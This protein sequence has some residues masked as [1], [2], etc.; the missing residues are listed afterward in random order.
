ML[1]TSLSSS[2]ENFMETLLYGKE[3]L[4]MKDVLATLNSRESK[5]RTKGTKEE[6]GDGLYVRKKRDYL[7]KK[8]SGFVK[9]GKRDQDF[10]SSN[11]E[12]N[13]YFGEAMV[14]VENDE[15]TE[16]VMDSGG[17]YHMTYK[18]DFLYEFKVVDGGS[19]RLV[20]Q[21]RL[22]DKQLEEKTNM[23]CLVKE[24]EKVLLG[25]KVGANI[26]VT[27]VPGQEGA[28]GNVAEKK[29]VNES[30][31]VN[32]GRLL[33]LSCLLLM[34]DTTRD[35][36][37]HDRTSESDDEDYMVSFDEISFSCKIISVDNL[38]TDNDNDND[39]VN[40]PSSLSPEPTFGYI[41]DLDF[42]KD[43]ENEFPAIA[44]NDLKSK[45]FP[46]IEPSSKFIGTL[47]DDPNL[48]GSENSSSRPN[49]RTFWP[50]PRLL[51]S[52]VVL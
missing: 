2:Y 42:F 20:A 25:I 50:P 23:D 37:F 43:F 41:D 22:E 7:K 39:K 45:S 51:Q 21:R 47:D 52:S 3:S 40:M 34:L 48:H 9:K 16:L 18:R 17:F 15:M 31:K 10:D 32:L 11:D 8:S 26:I 35:L 28:K 24:Q 33:N 4:T 27:G 36:A 14:V 46:L 13:A 38:K 44:Y 5:K 1:I 12:G 6:A 30:M 29:K 19:V 49:T